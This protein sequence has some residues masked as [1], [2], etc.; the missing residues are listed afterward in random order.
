MSQFNVGITSVGL[1]IPEKVLTNAELEKLVDTSDEWITTR[2]GIRE[3]RIHQGPTSDLAAQALRQAL[4]ARQMDPNELDVIIV[5]T[6]TP[7]H[8]FPSTACVTQAKVG[9]K[10]AWCFDLSAACSGFLYALQVGNQ[11]IRSGTAQRVAVIGADVMSTIINYKD[12]NTCI[13]FG[14]G[15]ACVLLEPVEGR[16]IIDMQLYSDGSTSHLLT[17]PAGGSAQPVTPEVY[18]E[19]RQY[20]QM[21]GREVF[22]MAVTGMNESCTKILADNKIASADVAWLVAHQAN[23]RILEATRERLNLPSERVY[24]NLERFGNTTAATIPLC[25]AELQHAKR[26]RKGDLVLL[27][28]FG[29]GSTWGAGIVEWAYDPE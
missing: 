10:R 26:L 12:R 3:R 5:A 7:D 14:D 16:G 15:G 17:I 1:A 22:R 11:L 18:A 19:G 2:T 23:I 20:V 6:S 27:T 8:F 29:A 9:A 4:H 25:L 21:N 28:A 24:S 13:L